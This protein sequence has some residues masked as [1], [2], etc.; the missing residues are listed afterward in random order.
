MMADDNLLAEDVFLTVPGP[1]YV[2]SDV[3][4]PIKGESGEDLYLGRGD[5][6]AKNAYYNNSAHELVRGGGPDAPCAG[7]VHGQPIRD[8]GSQCACVSCPA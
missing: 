6:T 5:L 8:D 7:G 2:G 3:F 1:D 4:E